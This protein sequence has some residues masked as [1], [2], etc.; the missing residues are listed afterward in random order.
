M[1]GSICGIRSISVECTLYRGQLRSCLRENKTCSLNMSGSNRIWN[2][3]IRIEKRGHGLWPLHI[4]QFIAPIRIMI[5]LKKAVRVQ[6]YNRILRSC[7][8]NTIWAHEHS[9]GGH[10]RCI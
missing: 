4:V 9:Y 5:A 7:F 10:G 8:I 2:W 3:R 6:L 1:T